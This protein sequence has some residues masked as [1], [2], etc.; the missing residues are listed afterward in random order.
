MSTMN[1]SEYTRKEIADKGRWLENKLLSPLSR[2]LQ[3]RQLAKAMALGVT[4]GL[5]PSVWGATLLCCLLSARLHL[6]QAV[7]QLA[8]YLVYPLQIL[9]LVPYFQLGTI[10]FPGQS[11]PLES[12]SLLTLFQTAP[13]DTAV[14]LWQA[15]LQAI[16]VWLLTTPLIAGGT[17][18]LSLMLINRLRRP[19]KDKKNALYSNLVNSSLGANTNL[20]IREHLPDIN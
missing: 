9:F 3:P 13:L 6:N 20:T 11:L 5:I 14:W 18:A 8:N 2:G 19:N 16:A 1:G 4:I 10:L 7:V 15:N 12:R 17:F